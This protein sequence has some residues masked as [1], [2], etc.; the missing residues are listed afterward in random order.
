MTNSAGRHADNSVPAL[1]VGTLDLTH[2]AADVRVLR[3]RVD[4]AA[5]P[6]FWA[7]LD[8][9]VSRLRGALAMLDEERAPGAS[10]S[11]ECSGA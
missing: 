9:P 6:E 5:I 7:T 3:I 4:D 11:E 2:N 8:I 1:E 10:E